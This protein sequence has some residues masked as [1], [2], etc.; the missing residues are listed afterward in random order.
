MTTFTKTHFEGIAEA[1]WESRKE[2][3]P[4]GP[5]DKAISKVADKIA[6]YLKSKNP[7]FDRGRFYDAC[8]FLG[9]NDA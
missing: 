4:F 1:I 5:E 3:K 2:F 7:N 6:D 8:G 9:R